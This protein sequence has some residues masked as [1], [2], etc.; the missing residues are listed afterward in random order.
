[1]II[2]K[3]E[4]A[5][6]NAVSHI[7]TE[8]LFAGNTTF[9]TKCPNWKQWD[10]THLKAC[11]LVAEEEGEIRGWAA[12]R[13]VSSRP[14]YA[15]VA[16][17][18][19]YI[20][21]KYRRL[22]IGSALLRALVICSEKAGIW[23]LQSS[24]LRENSASLRLHVRCGF[25]VVGFRERIGRDKYGAWRDTVLLERRSDKVGIA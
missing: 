21:E 17:V 20:L 5:D 1:M 23:T 25:R 22:G 16:E 13:P 7:Y 8:G 12:L 10:S 14:V 18:S 15:G 4:P 3:M 11:R 19:V 9:Q 2:R 24:I 6:W